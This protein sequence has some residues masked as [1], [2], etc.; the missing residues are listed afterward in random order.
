MILLQ[1]NTIEEKKGTDAPE[2]TPESVLAGSSAA[3][4]PAPKI[5]GRKKKNKTKVP[6]GKV[7]IND[8]SGNNS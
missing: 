6:K 4:A 8:S 7:F 5:R 1:D 3:A 2:E